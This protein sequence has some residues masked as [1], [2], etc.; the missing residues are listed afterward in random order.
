MAQGY[1]THARMSV[2]LRYQWRLAPRVCPR[3][4]LFAFGS[5]VRAFGRPVALRR[6]VPRAVR[7]ESEPCGGER[8]PVGGVRNRWDRDE[9]ALAEPGEPGVHHLVHFR[10]PLRRK[11]GDIIARPR[12]KAGGR[13]P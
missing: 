9:L 3:R 2:I 5:R 1:A 12:L 13:L 11:A 6:M 8:F 7:P 10:N 4:R